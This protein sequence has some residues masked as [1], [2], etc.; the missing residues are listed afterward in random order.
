MAPKR[1]KDAKQAQALL[2]WLESLKLPTRVINALRRDLEV[3]T[4][5]RKGEDGSGVLAGFDRVRFI[6]ELYRPQGGQVGN[7]PSVA[8]GAIDSL[9]AA[10]PALLRRDS[11]EATQPAQSDEEP[12]SFADAA[13]VDAE[14]ATLVLAD[15]AVPA[16]EQSSANAVSKAA[17]EPTDATLA[18]PKRRGRPPRA[19]KVP[20]T[21]TRSAEM[22]AA[23]AKRRGRP[24]HKDHAPAVTTARNQVDRPASLRVAPPTEAFT[25]VLAA[26]VVPLVTNPSFDVLL[27]LWRKLH[28]QGK[29]AAMHYM[30]SLMAEA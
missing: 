30:A 25:P 5:E 10:I 3:I 22:L 29:R 6:E 14:P 19:A 15:A 27:Q 17:P 24:S 12:T 11:T 2:V 9:R 4:G 26:P 28:P 16:P 21:A 20:E 13:R 1:T 18:S 8:K 23:P 7:V